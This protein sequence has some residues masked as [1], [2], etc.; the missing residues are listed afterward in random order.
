MFSRICLHLIWLFNAMTPL[1]LWLLA[2][3][4]S[5]DAPRCYMV[6]RAERKTPPYLN[7]NPLNKF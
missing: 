7:I 6:W 3:G 1:V 4:Y 5:G 2:P